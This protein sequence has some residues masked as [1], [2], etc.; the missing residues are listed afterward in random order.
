M[1]GRNRWAIGPDSSTQGRRQRLPRL[2]RRTRRG[3]RPQQQD[4]QD[5]GESQG[6]QQ[7][8]CGRRL[9]G[10]TFKNHDALIRYGNFMILH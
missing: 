8:A 7:P 1:R 4:M 6:G 2:L 10:N 9:S 5:T 3:V